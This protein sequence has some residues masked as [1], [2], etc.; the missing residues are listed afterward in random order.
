MA[1]VIVPMRS[2]LVFSPGMSIEV[3]LKDARR[4]AIGRRAKGWAGDTTKGEE[5]ATN[6]QKQYELLFSVH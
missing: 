4:T 1:V 2:V 3:A 5:A 6:Y